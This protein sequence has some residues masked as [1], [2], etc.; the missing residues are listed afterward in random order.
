MDY[1]E[2]VSNH[3]NWFHFVVEMNPT[4]GSCEHGNENWG[5]KK[6]EGF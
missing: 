3:V 4:V 2:I 6:W 5:F 1:Q